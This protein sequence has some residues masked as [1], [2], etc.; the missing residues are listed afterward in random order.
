MQGMSLR[1]GPVCVLSLARCEIV[2]GF[3]LLVSILYFPMLCN[4]ICCFV[5]NKL[6]M[7]L[8]IWLDVEFG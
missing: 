5:R 2:R 8:T 3:F 1:A 6:D 4:D 7:G